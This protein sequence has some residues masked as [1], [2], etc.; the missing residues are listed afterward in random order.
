MAGPA[1][2]PPLEAAFALAAPLALALA[3]FDFTLSPP[4][5][6][7]FSAGAFFGMKGLPATKKEL[8]ILLE[9]LLSLLVRWFIGYFVMT[10][11]YT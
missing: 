2:A 10:C 9:I 11:G 4:G 6:S 5:F 8:E 1:G 7:V 3:A